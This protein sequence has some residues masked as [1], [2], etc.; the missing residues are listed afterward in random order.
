MNHCLLGHCPHLGCLS[1][2]RQHRLCKG[3]QLPVTTQV[4]QHTRVELHTCHSAGVSLQW[5]G[6]GRQPLETLP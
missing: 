4:P 2:Q 6:G 3:C 5:G 1:V